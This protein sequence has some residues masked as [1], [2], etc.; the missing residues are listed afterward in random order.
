MEHQA[1]SLKNNAHPFCIL[2]LKEHKSCAII[3]FVDAAH[4]ETDKRGG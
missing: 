3:L 1:N 2:H 4:P